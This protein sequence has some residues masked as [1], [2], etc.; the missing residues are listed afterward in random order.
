[1]YRREEEGHRESSW[2]LPQLS[3]AASHI[4]TSE[5]DTDSGLIPSLHNKRVCLQ[6]VCTAAWHPGAALSSL[7]SPLRRP[8]PILTAQVL[9]ERER[10]RARDWYTTLPSLCLLE[11]LCRYHGHHSQWITTCLSTGTGHSQPPEPQGPG[12][13]QAQQQSKCL[14]D[15]QLWGDTPSAGVSSHIPIRSMEGSLTHILLCVLVPGHWLMTARQLA[16]PQGNSLYTSL[17]QFHG[18]YGFYIYCTYLLYNL[19][20][21]FI[22]LFFSVFL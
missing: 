8:P 15:C 12:T 4:P 9:C 21:L 2:H 18:D 6:A 20:R 1:M 5:R 7:P 11:E 17:S 10:E 14:I 13:L 22:L 3:T 16:F 19:Y